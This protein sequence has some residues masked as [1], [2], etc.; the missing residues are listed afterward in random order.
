ML[1]VAQVGVANWI[2]VLYTK[3]RSRIGNILHS[4]ES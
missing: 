2:T 3:N 4:S 1:I